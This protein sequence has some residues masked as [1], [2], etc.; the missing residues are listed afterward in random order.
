MIAAIGQSIDWGK[1]DVGALTLG[2]KNTA[3]AD[4]VTYQT[5]QEDI[6]VVG[7]VFTGP[8]FAIDAIAAGRE[9][10]ISLHRYVH[11]G[12]S[13][14]IARDLRRYTELNKD[15]VAL[16][17]ECFDAPAR[18]RVQHD[19][20]KALSMS[21]DSKVFT[22]EMIKAEATRC[23]GCGISIIDTNRCIGC[24]LCT[25]KCEFDAIHLERDVP[26]CSDLISIDVKMRG[27]LPYVAK[28]A[29]RIAIK[30]L[31]DALRK[32]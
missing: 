5:A 4:A 2:K 21:D 22:E 16:G 25:T 24:G 19:R 27:I 30:D 6:F 20:K 18:Q 29:G 7:D 10:A 17:L 12:Q 32:Q 23:L 13:L 28:R 14:T 15:K 1:L 26:E 9:G 31:K 3:E 11:P 8:R